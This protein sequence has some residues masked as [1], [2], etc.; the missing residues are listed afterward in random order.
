MHLRSGKA[1]DVPWPR[2][3]DVKPTYHENR[4]SMIDHFRYL[5]NTRR[6][7]T[8]HTMHRL[9]AMEIVETLIA[10]PHLLIESHPY[11]KMISVL[12][13]KFENPEVVITTFDKEAYLCRI[14]TLF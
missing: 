7:C 14:R 12:I 5:T 11:K 13:E 4:K 9:T 1:V 8:N 6:G 2:L 10:N 3:S